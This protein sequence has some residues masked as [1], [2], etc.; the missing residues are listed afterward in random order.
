MRTTILALAL[1][2]PLSARA[3]DPCGKVVEERANGSQVTLVA[4]LAGCTEATFTLTAELENAA[5]SA[6][7]PLTVDMT[8]RTRLVLTTIRRVDPKAPWRFSWHYD[9][10]SGR[11]RADAPLPVLYALPF[12][13][14]P[15][16]LAQGPHGTFSHGEGSQ[17]EEAFDWVM[18]EGTK[19]Y[20]ARAGTVVG[21]RS[22]VTEGGP[23]LRYKPDFNYVVVLHE[24]GTL[25][26]YAH[27][28]P[29]GVLAKL[30]EKV[31]PKRPLG[32]SGNTGRSTEPHL[33]F[34]VFNTI[35]G[36]TRTTWPVAFKGRDGRPLEMVPGQ[37]Y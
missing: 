31:T 27:L 9:W 26:E 12:H 28:Q 21:T 32:L 15:F 13:D 16:K 1:L 37:T 24:D 20:P 22:D 18:P 36:K 5:S 6:P 7:V 10:K 4:L 17:D 29:H 2:L 19:I 34:S 11:R 23:E 14:G 35:D 25:A 30:G 8:G 33:H 3:E